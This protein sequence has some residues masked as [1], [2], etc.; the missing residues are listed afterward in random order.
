[1]STRLK[2]CLMSSSVSWRQSLNQ[3]CEWL[4][5]NLD[6]ATR[7]FHHYKGRHQYK[8]TFSFGHCPNKGGGVYPCPDFLAPFVYQVLVLKIAFFYSNF[9]VIV[10]FFS[11]FC[12]NYHQ[13]YHNYH[14]NYH[15]NLHYQHQIFF[16]VIHAKRRFW[17]KKR[18]PSCPNLGRGGRGLG[19]DD[20]L[21]GCFHHCFLFLK[22]FSILLFHVWLFFSLLPNWKFFSEI[23]RTAS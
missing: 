22:Q 17:R 10:C 9:T 4:Y 12:H 2:I 1:M 19:D 7:S 14:H 8:K 6:S 15:C 21:F 5:H 11:H 20:S 13:N 23:L 3:L 18:G 16:P